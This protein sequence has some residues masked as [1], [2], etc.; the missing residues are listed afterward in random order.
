MSSNRIGCRVLITGGMQQFIGQTG[1]IV[2]KEDHMYRVRLDQPVDIPNV[3]VVGDD[4]W[5][6]QYLKT[7]PMINR[8]FL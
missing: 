3:G 7:I 8:R 6:S 5:E 4:L 1:T 2:S